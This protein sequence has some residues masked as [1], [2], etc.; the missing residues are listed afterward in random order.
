MRL[1]SSSELWF[2]LALSLCGPIQYL[3][4]VERDAERSG[5]LRENGE[6]DVGL[7]LMSKLMLTADTDSCDL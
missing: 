7:L 4:S 3:E 6:T 1:M 2:N 5:S